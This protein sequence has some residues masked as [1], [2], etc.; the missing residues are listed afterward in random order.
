MIVPSINVRE[1]NCIVDNSEMEINTKLS[2]TKM[3]I[4]Y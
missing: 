3:R 2:K 1:D 4:K